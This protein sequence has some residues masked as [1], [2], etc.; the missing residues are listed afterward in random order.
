MCQIEIVTYI[1]NLCTGESYGFDLHISYIWQTVGHDQTSH[2]YHRVGV[3]ERCFLFTPIVQY[4]VIIFAK[5][6]TTR[7][8][9]IPSYE[10]H[11][12]TFN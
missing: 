10:T 6:S 3:I 8:R 2:L 5:Q 4:G 1:S 7:V 11:N 12:I 9:S